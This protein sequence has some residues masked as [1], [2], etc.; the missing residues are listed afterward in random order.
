MVK[1]SIWATVRESYGFV[2]YG[3]R[4]FASLATPAIVVLAILS[5]LVTWLAASTVPGG[6]ENRMAGPAGILLVITVP[7]SIFLWVVFSVAWHRAFLKPNESVTVSGALKWGRRQS[8]FLLLTIAVGLLIV[9]IMA[10]GALVALAASSLSG[11][12]QTGFAQNNFLPL[13]LAGLACALVMSG[14]LALLFPATTVDH[15]MTFGESWETTRGNGWRIAIIV[16][17]VALPIWVAARLLSVPIMFFGQTN[18]LTAM[19]L[20]GLV[21]QTL[22]FIGVAVGVSA[23]SIA[24]RVIMDAQT[25]APM[26]GE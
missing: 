24:Y 20:A 7:A 8:R 11:V 26:A 10:G 13:Y 23:L 18:S 5:T 19:L 22:G 2:W 6:A 1:V 3:R 4:R 21:D 12:D 16:F 25:R 14:R 9:L 15:R 17:L